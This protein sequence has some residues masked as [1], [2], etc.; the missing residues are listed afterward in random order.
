[1]KFT[2]HNNIINSETCIA[3]M[4]QGICVKGIIYAKGHTPHHIQV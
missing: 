4:L 2:P 1:M 3:N